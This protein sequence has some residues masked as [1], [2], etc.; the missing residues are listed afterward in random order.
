MKKK[1]ES[2]MNR[3]ILVLGVIGALAL[4]IMMIAT[5][6]TSIIDDTASDVRLGTSNSINH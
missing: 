1:Q 5:S 6:G 4:V 2:F 3:K